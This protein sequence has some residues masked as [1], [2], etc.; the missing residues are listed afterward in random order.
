MIMISKSW[1]IY[2]PSINQSDL[3]Y[4]RM[5]IHFNFSDTGL[6]QS[7][8]ATSVRM[9]KM[10]QRFQQIGRLNFSFHDDDGDD[11]N[12]ADDLSTGEEEHRIQDNRTGRLGG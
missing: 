7:I 10:L 2:Y 12:G 6:C 1:H 8:S 3:I 4:V 5:V 11:N 9:P